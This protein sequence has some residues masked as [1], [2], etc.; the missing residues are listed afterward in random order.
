VAMQTVL[1]QKRGRFLREVGGAGHLR[2]GGI[3][4]GAEADARQEDKRRAW[5][6]GFARHEDSS[7][8][9]RPRRYLPREA[10]NR[11]LQSITNETRASA[12]SSVRRLPCTSSL[13]SCRQ[14]GSSR[15]STKLWQPC[16]Q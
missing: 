10:M 2:A 1:L 7:D 8:L 6:Q 13:S 5:R 3:S 14:S 12:K 16:C 9:H 4:G 15:C 11:M